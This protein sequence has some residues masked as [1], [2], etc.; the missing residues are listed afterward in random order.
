[1]NTQAHSMM[2]SYGNQVET[3]LSSCGHTC[4]DIGILIAGEVEETEKLKNLLKGGKFSFYV[5]V[6]R[7]I[8]TYQKNKK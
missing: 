3:S 6:D 5:M 4:T 1:M 8:F 2:C 7:E